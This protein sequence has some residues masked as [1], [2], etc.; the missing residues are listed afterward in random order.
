MPGT[1]AY[2]LRTQDAVPD[3]IE[4]VPDGQRS[5]STSRVSEADRPMS[6]MS[7]GGMPIP[8]TIVEKVDPEEASHGEVPGTAAF[9]KRMADAVP[10]EILKSPVEAASP[11][12]CKPT[13]PIPAAK[14]E[15]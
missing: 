10:D 6:P 8:K 4:V 11:F 5:R 15:P 3:E 1:P 9:E 7:P 13:Q 2:Q 14:V 12:K